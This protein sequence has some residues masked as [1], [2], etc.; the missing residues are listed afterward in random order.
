MAGLLPGDFVARD[1]VV[2]MDLNVQ[3]R[4]DLAQPLDEVVG[5]R[6]VVVDQEDQGEGSAF[7]VQKSQ[8]NPIIGCRSFPRRPETCR[9]RSK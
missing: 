8:N 9:R 5:K 6:V 3:R 1:F 4:I 2:A 7:R